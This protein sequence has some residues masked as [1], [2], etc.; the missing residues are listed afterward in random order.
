VAQQGHEVRI[1]LVSRQDHEFCL[2]KFISFGYM[3][4]LTKDSMFPAPY[5][6]ANEDVRDGRNGCKDHGEDTE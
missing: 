2:I 6:N 5:S 4:W 3:Q 1:Q